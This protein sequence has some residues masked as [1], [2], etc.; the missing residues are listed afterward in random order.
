MD[1][2]SAYQDTLNYI[3]SFVDYSLTRSFRYSPEKFDLDR[4]YEFVEHLG[5]PQQAYPIIHVAGTKGKGSVTA[6]CASA[7]R[8]EGYRVGLYT[9]PHLQ[10]YAERIQV[11]GQQI[12]HEE[13]IDLVEEIKP[14]LDKGTRLTTFE[15]TTALAFLYFARRGVSAAVAEVG[16]GGRLDATN[17][18]EPVVSVIT[19]IS[20][21]HTDILGKTLMEIAG[22]KAGIIKPG[23][24]VVVAPQKEEARLAIVAKAVERSA[25]LTQV[26]RDFLFAPVSHSLASQSMLVWETSEQDLIDAYI[27][28]GGTQEWEPTRLVIPLL[29]Y[30]QVENA[31]TAYA[32]LQVSRKRGLAISDEAIRIGFSRTSWPGR[33][34]V[35]SHHPLVVVDSAH[36]RDSALKLRLALDDYFPGKPVIL[37]FGAS[38]DK[39]IEGMFAELMPRVRQVIATQSYHPRAMETERLVE[40]V[41]RFGR[42]VKVVAAVEDALAEAVRL[43]ENGAMVLVT[44]SIFVA[45]GAR[46]T[47]YS[48]VDHATK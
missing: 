22:E 41:H 2:E 45:A 3:Y 39:D 28:S 4:M 34:E 23:I 33:F 40:M 5:N 18:V 32:A 27:E 36:N 30:H 44:G 21:D 19:S 37:V 14:F 38:E 8:A 31:A 13:L 1:I 6:M 43:S 7:L 46:H 48:G 10:D 26:G 16:L 25:P 29:G 9:S 35:L 24:P 15:I 47:W 17:V 11:D 42:P 12:Q 20:Y